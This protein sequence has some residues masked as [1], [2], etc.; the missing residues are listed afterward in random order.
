MSDDYKYIEI[1]DISL[2]FSNINWPDI[3]GFRIEKW[4]DK[5]PLIVGIFGR[6][7]EQTENEKQI[8]LLLQKKDLNLIHGGLVF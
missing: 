5:S 8:E 3:Y 6:S 2:T 4:D 7:E 1:D